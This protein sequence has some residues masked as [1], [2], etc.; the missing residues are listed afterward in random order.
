MS[1][2]T[3]G[4]VQARKDWFIWKISRPRNLGLERTCVRFAGTDAKRGL[5]GSKDKILIK[6][7]IVEFSQV[8]F[9]VRMSS[10]SLL[11]SP[12]DWFR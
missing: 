7:V 6:Y 9:H 10:I 1:L 12:L 4:L 5:T 8:H 2:T 3:Y 11:N